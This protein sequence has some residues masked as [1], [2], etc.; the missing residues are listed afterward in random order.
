MATMNSLANLTP[1]QVSPDLAIA[2]WTNSHFLGGLDLAAQVAGVGTIVE[3]FRGGDTYQWDVERGA[4]NT[5]AQPFDETTPTPA[6]GSQT[7]ARGTLP[8]LGF[9]AFIS[10]T[11]SAIESQAGGSYIAGADYGRAGLYGELPGAVRDVVHLVNTTFLTSATHGLAAAIDD[12]S[13]T[14]IY[15]NLSRLLLTDLQAAVV[16]L[17]G[18]AVALANL[19]TLEQTMAD[20]PHGEQPDVWFMPPNQAGRIFNIVGGPS[21]T[22]FIRFNASDAASGPLDAGWKRHDQAFAGKPVIEIPNMVNTEIYAVPMREI[23]MITPGVLATFDQPAVGETAAL[24]MIRTRLVIVYKN[25]RKLG[26]INNC[27]V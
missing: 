7:Y 13:S 10:V 18:G 24:Q 14:V 25:T 1:P 22:S 6:P 12:G 5:S 3:E 11:H 8:Y 16:N 19:T 26:K 27:A 20:Q 4:G 2:R 21:A 9:R 23:K 15:G 17:G